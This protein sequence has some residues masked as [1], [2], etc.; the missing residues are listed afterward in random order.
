MKTEVEDLLA[1][2][3]E[4]LLNHLWQQWAML[5]SGGVALEE[6][7]GFVIDPEAL[8][9]ATLRF[10]TGDGRL[11]GETLSW[12]ASHGG[13]LSLQRAKNLQRK[14]E[15]G[16][17]GAVREAAEWMEQAG[18]RNWK[19]LAGMVKG[20]EGKGQSLVSPGFQVREHGQP[21]QFQRDENFL[22]RMRM[23]FGVNARPEVLT[24]LLCRG[25]GYPAQIAEETGWLAKS[26]QTILGEFE[27]GGIVSSR[28]EGRKRLFSLNRQNGF[29]DGKLGRKMNWR[30]QGTRYLGWVHVV[31]GLRELASSKQASAESRSIRIRRK[32]GALQTAFGVE[33]GFT[34]FVGGENLSGE[35]MVHFFLKEV[36]RQLREGPG[37]GHR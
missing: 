19:S 9:L 11:V 23:I 10:G 16:P 2:V 3:E 29:L 30:M 22:L 34:G 33:G 12:L 27:R 18:F 1:E 15:L 35:E 26:V 4:S 7:I 36:K 17:A 6:R 37:S 20:A 13:M 28:G 31:D 21:I 25:S 5:G 8:L 32:M 14:T 24:W